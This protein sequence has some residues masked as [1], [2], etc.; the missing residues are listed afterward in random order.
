MGTVG[1]S[2]L[3]QLVIGGGVIGQ[4]GPAP[5]GLKVPGVGRQ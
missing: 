5:S 3:L 1:G 4:A 2:I